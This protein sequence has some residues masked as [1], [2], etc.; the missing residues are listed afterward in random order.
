M[1][2][3]ISPLFLL[4]GAGGSGVSGNCTGDMGDS[5]GEGEAIL[6]AISETD[7]V[8]MTPEL[9]LLYVTG[10]SGVLLMAG[11]DCGIAA[12]AGKEG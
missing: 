6:V 8:A 1:S 9:P 3:T 7:G 4:L 11:V 2:A 5:A 12:R 10:V